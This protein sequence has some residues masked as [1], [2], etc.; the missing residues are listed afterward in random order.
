MK[1]PTMP[2]PMPMPMTH[3]TRTMLMPMP[4]PHTAESDEHLRAV[5]EEAHH[6][7]RPPLHPPHVREHREP[8]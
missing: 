2:I 1:K 6:E 4:M 3:T 5:E 8:E 7:D